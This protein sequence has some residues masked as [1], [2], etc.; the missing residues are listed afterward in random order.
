MNP[1]RTV[2]AVIEL[3]LG[4]AAPEGVLID[5]DGGARRFHGWLELAGAIE[6]WRA[7][8]AGAGTGRTTDEGAP[9]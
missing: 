3:R 7:G 4:T 1:H 6:E 8:A 2:T 5:A 9:R